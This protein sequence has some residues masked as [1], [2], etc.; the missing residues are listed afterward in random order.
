M[1]ISKKSEEGLKALQHTLKVSP[2]IQE[3]HFTATG[4]HYFGAEELTPTDPKGKKTGPAKKYGYLRTEP[5]V[6]KIVG[7]RKFFKHVS[8]ATPEAEIVE[9][10]SRDEVLDYE[11]DAEAMPEVKTGKRKKKTEELAPDA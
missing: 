8:V 10:L 11:F 2:H 6:S 7:E 1:S 4:E 9:S 3:V 5:Q